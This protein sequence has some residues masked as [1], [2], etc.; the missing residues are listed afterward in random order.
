MQNS[1]S[2]PNLDNNFGHKAIKIKKLRNLFK[3]NSIKAKLKQTTTVANYRPANHMRV[4]AAKNVGYK[5]TQL[6]AQQ[7]QICHVTSCK[8]DEKR[9]IKPKIVL[10]VDPR[11][12]FRNNF[13]QP[14][15]KGSTNIFVARQVDHTRWKMRNIDPRLATKKCCATRSRF[16]YLIFRCLYF[17]VGHWP[18]VCYRCC[19]F[20]FFRV[21]V[22]HIL[23]P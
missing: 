12:T 8:F 4:K 22:S 19:L 6:V 9:E 2:V 17:R 10:K 11:S 7:E 14:C 18:I 23:P 5:N 3:L 21:L 1:A 15:N 20:R 13:P 16:L